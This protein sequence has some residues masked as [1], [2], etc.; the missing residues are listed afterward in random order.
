MLVTLPFILVA[1]GITGRWA[2]DPPSPATAWQAHP[3][4]TPCFTRT[5]QFYSRVN[6]PLLT[7]H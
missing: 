5:D 7:I 4:M 1:V 2:G 3:L 6:I